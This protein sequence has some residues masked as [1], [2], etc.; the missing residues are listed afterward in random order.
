ME[1]ADD[2]II[3]YYEETIMNM[4]RTYLKLFKRCKE[5][6]IRLNKE[7]LET[8]KDHIVFMGLCIT[9]DGLKID[10]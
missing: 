5:K 9:K 8:N 10:E 3:H 6:G 4:M 2:I 7:K 1:F